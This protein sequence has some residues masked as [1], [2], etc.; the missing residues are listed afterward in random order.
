VYGGGGGNNEPITTGAISPPFLQDFTSV[1]LPL[2]Y[3]LELVPPLQ[4][5]QFSIAS[6]PAEEASRL[7]LCVA[8]VVYRTPLLR[9]KHGVCSSWL[10]NLRPGVRAP[11]DCRPLVRPV[12][13]A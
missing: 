2:A 7:S 12:N 6:A 4:P 3:L 8:R 11:L 13:C 9:E 10:A 1:Q 5:R